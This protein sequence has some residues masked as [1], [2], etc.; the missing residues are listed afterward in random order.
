MQ[1]A[2]LLESQGV[3]VRVVSVPCFDLLIRQDLAFINRILGRNTKNS[4]E[5]AKDSR[6]SKIFALEASRGMEW[7]KFADFVIG[8]DSFGASGKGE[9][10]FERFGF[11][12]KGV[13][14]TILQNL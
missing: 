13:T 7:Y 12:V 3:A 8:M 4:G 6:E 2:K 10:V 9:A 5:S 11:S 1:S 14:K